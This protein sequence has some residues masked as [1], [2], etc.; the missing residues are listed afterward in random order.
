MQGQT[1]HGR[2][3][4]DRYGG[5]GT[6]RQSQQGRHGQQGGQDQ[7]GGRQDENRRGHERH[8]TPY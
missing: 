2:Q 7:Y 4:V 3:S 8:Q 1:R 5:E 6:D